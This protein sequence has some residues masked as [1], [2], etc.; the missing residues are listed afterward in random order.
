MRVHAFTYDHDG[1]EPLARDNVKA[2]YE[3]LGM[4]L[5]I[6]TLGRDTHQQS[7]RDYF[8]AWLEHPSTASAGMVSP[9]R[10]NSFVLRTQSPVEAPSTVHTGRRN[11]EA[12]TQTTMKMARTEPRHPTETHDS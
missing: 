10:R 12:L 4:P 1:V 5:S 2:V 7:F 8:S 3:G 9:S 11:S 6:E